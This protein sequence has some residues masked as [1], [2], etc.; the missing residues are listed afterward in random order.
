MKMI[1]HEDS[2]LKDDELKLGYHGMKTRGRER[3]YGDIKHQRF[4]LQKLEIGT[5]VPVG[6]PIALEADEFQL[7]STT[8]A[9]DV[10][11]VFIFT[12]ANTLAPKAPQNLTEGTSDED[13]DTNDS[14]SD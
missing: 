13:D 12:K 14:D 8:S 2:E 10:E 4:C 5:D 1:Q 11:K 7:A 3:W 9:K 6:E